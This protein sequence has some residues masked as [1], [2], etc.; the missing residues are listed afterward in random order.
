M[1]PAFLRNLDWYGRNGWTWYFASA[2]FVFLVEGI[3]LWELS[4]T[5]AHR[6]LGL[7][8]RIPQC[9]RRCCPTAHHPRYLLD[10]GGESEE[11]YAYY[12]WCCGLTAVRNL[13]GPLIDKWTFFS[14]HPD[15]PDWQS[16]RR[17]YWEDLLRWL[18]SR[19]VVSSFLRLAR[20]CGMQA[21]KHWNF[22][23]QVVPY[24]Y[25]KTNL[26]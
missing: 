8:C 12:V 26:P 5:W 24:E 23:W 16:I 10:L 3:C 4:V 19:Y 9:T 2:S 15:L 13:S 25:C 22:L 11:Q 17:T 1:N 21:Q 7:S 6:W 14:K 18:I 20:R